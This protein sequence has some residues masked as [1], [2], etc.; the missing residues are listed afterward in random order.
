MVVVY[1]NNKFNIMGFSPDVQRNS[2]V[3]TFKGFFLIVL[4]QEY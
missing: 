2:H 1:N 3:E 4:P